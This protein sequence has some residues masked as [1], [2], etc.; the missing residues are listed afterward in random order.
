MKMD[1]AK[2]ILEDMLRQNSYP[3]E[4]P[5]DFLKDKNKWVYRDQI[6]VPSI[7]FDSFDEVCAALDKHCS[8]LMQ[9]SEGV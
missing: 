3:T 5:I 8:D 4:C 9:L 2:I 6:D 7:E 1:M